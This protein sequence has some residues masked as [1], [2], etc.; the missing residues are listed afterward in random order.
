M[1]QQFPVLLKFI[2]CSRLGEEPKV[3]LEQL[4]PRPGDI[5]DRGALVFWELYAI[6]SVV[7]GVAGLTALQFCDVLVL[8]NNP[9]LSEELS[10]YCISQESIIGLEVLISE[11]IN[12]RRSSL[13][14]IYIDIAAMGRQSGGWFCW[15][16]HRRCRRR[17]QCIFRS[18]RYGSWSRLCHASKSD[19]K[20]SGPLRESNK[21]R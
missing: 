9:N 19:V 6:V 20:Q 3:F 21:F 16:S 4:L 14:L 10:F 2:T 5:W 12:R 18:H 8:E 1:A 13:E 11:A 17:R 7:K 15:S